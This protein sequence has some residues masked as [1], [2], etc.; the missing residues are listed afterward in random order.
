MILKCA[1][2]NL[3]VRLRLG[4]DKCDIDSSRKERNAEV[5]PNAGVRGAGESED[6][7]GQAPTFSWPFIDSGHMEPLSIAWRRLVLSSIG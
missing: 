7:G 2:A 5:R 4:V 6:V 1:A 3:Q